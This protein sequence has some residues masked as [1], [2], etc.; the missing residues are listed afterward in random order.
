MAVAVAP[1]HLLARVAAVLLI[2][3]PGRRSDELLTYSGTAPR[4][5]EGIYTDTCERGTPLPVPLHPSKAACLG[6][7]IMIP[8]GLTDRTSSHC[9][10]HDLVCAPDFRSVADTAETLEF[11]VMIHTGY[12]MGS[13]ASLGARGARLVS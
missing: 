9:N 1:A 5:V 13:L 4:E 2:A 11:G 3:D 10:A 8:A 6:S 7:R 12:G